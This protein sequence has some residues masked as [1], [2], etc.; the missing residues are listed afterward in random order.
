MST[1]AHTDPHRVRA[2]NAK[3]TPPSLFVAE[4]RFFHEDQL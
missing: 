4:V 2:E 1:H 3:T